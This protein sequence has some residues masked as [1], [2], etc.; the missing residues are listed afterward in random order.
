MAEKCRK[1]HRVTV[2]CST[3]RG[4]GRA[5]F[6]NCTTCKGT[7]YVCPEHGKHWQR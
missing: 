2:K 7:G 3:C 4:T 5:P 1:C 6:G